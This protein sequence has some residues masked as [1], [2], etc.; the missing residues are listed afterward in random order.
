[1][2]Q[3]DNGTIGN[4][5]DDYNGSDLDDDGIGDTPYI[6]PGPGGNQDNFPIWDD[7]P[8]TPLSL[9]DEITTLID[10]GIL[11]IGQGNALIS[12][13]ENALAKINQGNLNA[14]CNILQ[15]FINQIHDLI[16]TGV[17]SQEEGEK[18][19]IIANNIINNISDG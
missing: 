3:W 19:I 11:N 1:M 18:L 10:D 17:I 6:I 8:E 15:A 14:A 2:N 7:D 4:Y 13:L 12:K 5:W 9:I 16:N